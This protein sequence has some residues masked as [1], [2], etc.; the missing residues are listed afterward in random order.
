MLKKHGY[1]RAG[2][3][4]GLCAGLLIP[5]A[6]HAEETSWLDDHLVIKGFGTLGL[7][8]S[9]NDAAEYVRD[10]SQ[11]RGL[12]TNWSS[13]V[14]SLLGLQAN[15]KLGEQTE[16]VI[17]LIS[18]YRYDGSYRPEISW[19]FLRHDFTPDFQMRL[20]RLG[21]EFYMLADSRLIGYANLTVRPPP[22][23]YGPLIFSYFDGVDATASMNVGNDLLRAKLFF[24][25][26]PETTPFYGPITWDLDGS[27]LFG[28]HL[29]YF[30]GSWQFR[31]AH[32]EV[33]FSSH[34]APLNALVNQFIGADPVLSVLIPVPIDLTALVPELG[35]ARKTSKFDSFGVVYDKGPL[36]V[37]MMLGRIRHESES[38]EDSRAG[39]ITAAYRIEKF[40]PY[41]GYSRTKSKASNISTTPATPWGPL[42]VQ[43]ASSELTPSTHMDQHTYTAGTRWDFRQNW[44]L[45]IQ[46]D[47]VRGNERS[48]ILF[49]GTGNQWNGRMKVLSVALD[50]AF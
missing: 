9:D 5:L 35:M 40:T 18:R 16:G 43:I 41:L 2:R 44:A 49:R 19:A 15:L 10:L 14:D 28:G 26:S 30:T 33:K 48:N 11:P 29:D 31:L 1:L 38:Y 39:F 25:K 27:R 8:R 12:T 36:Q 42:A 23:F 4:L 3:L 20:G 47:S 37:Q 50:F 46:Y 6:G 22:D 7:A 45:K 34:E 17:Q 24:G 13:Q 21:T 32:A